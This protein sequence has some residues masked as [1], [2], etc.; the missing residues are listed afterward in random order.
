MKLPLAPPATAELI[1]TLSQSGGGSRLAKIMLLSQSA[2]FQAPDYLH[3]DKLRHLTPPEE[4]TS[5]EW[6][7]ALKWGR[8]YRDLPFLDK[9]GRAFKYCLPDAVLELLHQID[10]DASGA[11]QTETPILNPA[12]RDTFMV[13]SLM[14][15]AITSSQL[16]GAA[17][18]RAVAKE[19]L[20]EGRPPRDR[21]E[22]MIVNNYRG[23]RL[24]KT[25]A[26]QPLTLARILKLHRVMTIDTLDNKL[27]VGRLRRPEEDIH[28][29]DHR[30]GMLLHTPPAAEELPDRLERQCIFANEAK[31]GAFLHP[32]LRAIILHFALAYDHPFADGN[33]RTARALFYWSLLRHDYWLA[34]FVS[35]SPLLKQ[36]PAEYARA[37]LYSETDDNDLTYFILHQLQVFV[38]AVDDLHTYIKHKQ[39]EIAEI[40]RLLSRSHAVRTGLNYRQVALLRHALHHPNALYLIESHRQS[41]GITYQTARADLLDLEKLSLI[42]RAK[43]RAG[44][45]FVFCPAGDLS[46]RLRT[47]EL[48]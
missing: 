42:T 2:Q 45:A 31:T 21:S 6:W 44:R 5:E 47:R 9:H 25:F 11:I 28:V 29:V 32:V 23:M 8:R 43:V 27:A 13:R 41:H 40:E 18:T 35:I 36:A 26:D 1:R 48:S 19:M 46:K 22:R 39:S 15:E 20:R 3:W 4:L 12:I 30:D 10:Q 37:F 17:T 14:E 24:I 16:E 33:G 34:E 7:L 38:R